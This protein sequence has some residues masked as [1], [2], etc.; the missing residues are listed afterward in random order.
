MFLAFFFS[1]GFHGFKR[2]AVLHASSWAF[3]NF[4]LGGELKK[5]QGPTFLHP[6]ATMESHLTITEDSGFVFSMGKEKKMVQDNSH[7]INGI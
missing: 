6:L 1:F 2:K 5:A 3:S 4:V 7:R